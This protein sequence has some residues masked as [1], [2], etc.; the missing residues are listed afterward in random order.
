M[1]E[2]ARQ[3]GLKKFYKSWHC[4]V[5]YFLKLIMWLLIS[6]T[7]F[8]SRQYSYPTLKFFV[9]VL[10]LPPPVTLEFQRTGRDWVFGVNIRWNGTF[11]FSKQECQYLSWKSLLFLGSWTDIQYCCTVICTTKQPGW[12]FNRDC[13][14]CYI[15]QIVP[16]SCLKQI[17]FA[18]ESRLQSS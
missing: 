5:R 2:L 14:Y 7:L 17:I 3:S 13:T 16:V 12:P 8:S 9:F 18:L 4:Q 6:Q 11:R 15:V 10:E 1:Y